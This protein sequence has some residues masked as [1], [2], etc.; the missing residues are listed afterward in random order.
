MVSTYHV[1]EVVGQGMAQSIAVGF[2]LN[3]RV[4]FDAC[5][6]GFIVLVAEEEVRYASLGCDAIITNVPDV[7]RRV[8]DK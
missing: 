4:T 3:G 7:A 1:D 6:E 2:R 5:T 8:L